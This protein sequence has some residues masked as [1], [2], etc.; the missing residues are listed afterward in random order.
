[1]SLSWI[2][3]DAP[4]RLT[5]RPCPQRIDLQ[6]WRKAGADLVVSLLEP[7][8]TPRWSAERERHE[9]R[10]Q[11]LRFRS[12][13]VPD[14]GVPEDEEAFARLARELAA[15]IGGGA[16]V[17][18]HCLGGRGRSWLLG[19]S[20]LALHGLALDEALRRMRAARGEGGPETLEQEAWLRRFVERLTGR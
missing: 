18:V 10:R 15:E 8:E 4:G 14:Y 7:H 5:V 2:E 9:S 13:P 11:Q 19:A 20:V 3:L 6:R 12:F 1:M 16:S 17:V